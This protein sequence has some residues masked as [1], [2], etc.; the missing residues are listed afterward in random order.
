MAIGMEK[1]GLSMPMGSFITGA[2]LANSEV[3]TNIRNLTLPFKGILMGLFFMTLGINL[4]IKFIIENIQQVGLLCLAI[5]LTKSFILTAI[6]RI[7][8]G[9]YKTGIKVSLLL[10]QAGEFGIVVVGSALQFNIISTE[11]NKL[12][13]TSILLTMIIAPFIA[14]MTNLLGSSVNVDPAN[15]SPIGHS[16]SDEKK[17]A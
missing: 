7:R 2:F 5:V 4:E 14:R 10:S 1:I 6:G 11:V 17:A 8:S 9:N 16:T 3:K 12:V 15:V 13:A